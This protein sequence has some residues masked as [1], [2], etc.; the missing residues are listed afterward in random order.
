MNCFVSNGK[1]SSKL[2]RFVLVHPVAL[3]FFQPPC[4]AKNLWDLVLVVSGGDEGLLPSSYSKGIVHI[5]HLVKYKGVCVLF[6]LVSSLVICF[7]VRSFLCFRLSRCRSVSVSVF[8]C[9]PVSVSPGLYLS[10]CLSLSLYLCLFASV[11]LSVCLSVSFCLSLFLS[12][13][14]C[15]SLSL[16]FS[17]PFSLSL[18]LPSSTIRCPSVT[19]LLCASQFTEYEVKS[20]PSH[21][22]E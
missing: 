16:P 12:V 15:L 2:W 13:S 6:Y 18:S 1:H 21:A 20:M 11:C 3:L 8:H 22:G 5:K 9:L 19:L 17:L 4:G 14:F 10:L 7:S